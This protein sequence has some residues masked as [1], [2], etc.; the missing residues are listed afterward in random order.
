[1]DCEATLPTMSRKVPNIIEEGATTRWMCS[2]TSAQVECEQ[3][4]R[5][6]LGFFH[7]GAFRTSFHRRLVPRVSSALGIAVSEGRSS[8]ERPHAPAPWMLECGNLDET[9]MKGEQKFSS[10]HT[11]KPCIHVH[12]S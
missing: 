3:C 1:V 10:F 2:A 7:S 12:S 9:S 8:P 11:T 5:G 6:S 4:D